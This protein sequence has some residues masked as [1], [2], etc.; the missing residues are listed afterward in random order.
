[1]WAAT[2]VQAHILSLQFF[3]KVDK[4]LAQHVQSPGFR[5]QAL[6]KLGTM[7]HTFN[8]RIKEM[9]EG[10]S[11]V[12]VSHNQFEIS[13]LR[14]TL[15]PRDHFSPSAVWKVAKRIVILTKKTGS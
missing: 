8:P 13:L 9:E 11:E 5:V 12:Q 3:F 4:V 6:H 1:M 2:H 14:K 10:R 7:V 15:N